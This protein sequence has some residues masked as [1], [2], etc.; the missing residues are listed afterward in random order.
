M[1]RLGAAFAWLVPRR[2]SCSWE[3]DL[4]FMAAGGWLGFGLAFGVPSFF[5]EEEVIVL[6]CD[7]YHVPVAISRIFI[8]TLALVRWAD[9]VAIC[10]FHI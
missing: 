6:A 7:I 2:G 8:S 1:G 5:E 10:C 3:A 4:R 9:Y